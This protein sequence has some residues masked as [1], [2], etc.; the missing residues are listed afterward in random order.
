M[1]RNR[2]SATDYTKLLPQGG[3]MGTRIREFN[4]NEHP[5][6][7]IESWQPEL[8]MSM[9]TAL[10]SGFPTLIMWDKELYILYND[11][12]SKF[13]GT[14]GKH[15]YILGKRADEIW[16][17][18]EEIRTM[19]R[20]AYNGKSIYRENVHFPMDRNGTR[21]DAY[22]TFSYSPIFCGSEPGGV[23]VICNETTAQVLNHKQL[24]EKEHL[25]SF[26]VDATE[27][28]VWS[29]NP[30][31]QT[32]ST[33]QRLRDW[34]G[35]KT[36]HFTLEEALQSIA[37]SDRTRVD[38]E[39]R[40]A[41]KP[42]SGGIYNIDYTIIHPETGEKRLVHAKGK[43]WFENGKPTNF[44]GT[45]QDITSVSAY[46]KKLK[47]SERRFRGLIE[48]SPI[49]KCLLRGEDLIIEIA[50]EKMLQ[51]WDKPA[52]VIGSPIDDTDTLSKFDIQR[53][54]EMFSTRKEYSINEMRR[55]I[56]GKICYFNISFKAIVHTNG[57][58]FGI[59]QTAF[60]VTDQVIAR[61]QAERS[62][63]RLRN[64][65]TQA[66][67]AI[68]FFTGK[69][70][71]IEM[72]NNPMTDIL[73]RG[74]DII[75]KPLASIM[76]ELPSEMQPF[77][78]IMDD[79]FVSGEP[80]SAFG[81]PIRISRHGIITENYYDITYSP[82]FDNAGK[83]YGI[84]EIAV[85]VS[86]KVIAQKQI[87][88]SESRFRN[89][90]NS[91]PLPIG[92]YTGK[93]MRIMVANK[94]ITKIFGKGDNIVGKLYSEVNP[95]LEDQ[96]VFRQLQHVYETGN[97]FHAY[98][99][100][101]TLIDNGRPRLYYF[102]YSFTPLRDAS[103]TIYGVLNTAAD[104]TDI[105]TIRLSLEES[106]QKLRRTI[107]QAPVA[108]CILRGREFR[109]E[110]A[111]QK[112]YDLWGRTERMMMN[113]PLFESL[114]EAQGLGFEKLLEHV[115][116]T[117]ETYKASGVPAFA[118]RNGV[119]TPIYVDFVYEAINEPDGSISGIMVVAID[120]TENIHA[121]QKIEEAEHKARLAIES[122]KLG[123][124][125]LNLVTD[126]VR[127]SDRF[128]EIWGISGE[129][130]R[131]ALTSKI[132]PDDQPGRV[133]AHQEALKTG[134][135][136]YECRLI[137]EDGNLA[138]ISINGKITFDEN[139]KPLM[140]LGVIQDVTEQ[141]LF[142]EELSKQVK[143][144]TQ[145]LYR[146]NED[147]MQFAHV[148]SH[149]LKE[150]VRKIKVFSNMIEEQ[151]GSQ[152]PQKAHVYLGKV[153]SA[154]D[155]MFSMIE[156]VLAYS[157]LSASEQP[158]EMVDLNEIFGSIESDLEVII[159]QK[160]A[161]IETDEL[162]SIEGAQVLIY[163]LFYNLVN[164]ALKFSREGV[165]PHIKIN[166][167]IITDSGLKYC[168]LI[169]SDNGIGL[170]PEYAH[171]I[172]DAFARLHAKDR[173]E[174]TGLGL[175]LC[176]KIVERHHGSIAADGEEGKGATFTVLLPV[177]QKGKLL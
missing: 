141:R 114:Q 124:Y 17:E 154:T 5:L 103:G 76:S 60:D 140:L 30:D 10:N 127:V 55:E 110:I 62:E 87:V 53:I 20:D 51:F 173:Y 176:K 50:N 11:A 136:H 170:A 152:I 29:Y 24:A 42:E 8:T 1:N 43:V 84:M 80:F 172:F 133:L 146:S 82:V 44:T 70:H 49:A 28:G 160:H 112:M 68:G 88:E 150:P 151:F 75:G 100:G 31:V 92:V 123:T 145:E 90:V 34:F 156:G 65:I 98:N 67:I 161:V 125:E 126:E 174:G 177:E 59:M 25:L 86:E 93:E 96:E 94:A 2:S 164:N 166:S 105:N 69:D 41:M 35:V 113:K 99:A 169:V 77:L 13:L 61:Q 144:R 16:I 143:D 97:A 158:I 175:A 73:G 56:G 122:A 78:Q 168:R 162:P 14:D 153:Q 134:N 107:L 19:L 128:R 22:W 132:Y 36:E 54:R 155:R 120:M 138:Y 4:W 142:A 21:E 74:A 130:S 106:E 137:K 64:L 135:L 15:P 139:R 72:A 89:L 9:S 83:V 81:K 167:A 116:E 23:L 39:I 129:V 7:P 26:A 38:R 115:Y 117:G 171:K 12:F 3:E 95:E 118:L 33:N 111:N 6:G 101:I 91:A 66:P 104:V 52:S 63:E 147:L 48:Q 18:H 157:A 148:A 32:G 47:D 71:V 163:Q 45:L 119:V 37:D 27:L 58:I 165:A 108:M 79:V 57:E 102:N 109:V 131:E 40:K 149:D 85:D 159:Q 121:R 46:K